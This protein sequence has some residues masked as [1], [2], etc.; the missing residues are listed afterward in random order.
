MPTVPRPPQLLTEELKRQAEVLNREAPLRF[1]ATLLGFCV[2]GIYLPWWI[3]VMM[4]T[5]DLAGEIVSYR[6]FRNVEALARDKWRKQAVIVATFTLEYCFVL[7]AGMLWHLDDPYAKALAVG[8]AAGTMMHIA[9]TRSIHLPVGLSGALGLFVVLAGSNTSFWLQNGMWLQLA[10]TSVCIVVTMAYFVWA[11]VSNHRLHSSTAASRL[12]A[13]QADAAKGRFLAEMSH[14]LRT[15]LNGILGMA[16]AEMREATDPASRKRLAVLV[17]SANGL[18]ALLNDILDLSAMEEGRMAIRPRPLAPADEITSAVALFRPA[19]EASGRRLMLTLDPTLSAPALIDGHRLRQCLNNL[20]S[21]A[22][23]HGRTATCITVRAKAETPPDG[24]P[25]LA[26]EVE[27]DGPGLAPQTTAPD[28]EVARSRGHGLGL[29]I[30]RGLAAQMGGDVQILPPTGATG[31]RFRL[32][33]ALPPAA[34]VSLASSQPLA[35]P[36]ALRGLRVLVVDDV[37]TN[38]LVATT[39]LRHLGAMA[40]EADSGVE[41][42]RRLAVEMVDLVLLDMNMPDLDGI[43]TLRRLRALPPPHG[44]VAVV[45][46]TADAMDHHRAHF[47]SQGLDGYL[48]KPISAERIAAEVQRVMAAR[49]LLRA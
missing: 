26:V 36:L 35:D 15:P 32:T 8:L 24:P 12:A 10:I 25:L 20:L 44:T 48:S 13:Q 4:M 7:P 41:A 11:M 37:A 29:S 17:D 38:R 30:S 23:R 31:A 16:D 3:I 21:N 5:G 27:D 33:I 19:A 42:L 43:E 22:I 2:A 34:P 49:T 28:D 39:Q 6:L 18:N 14:E 46:L 1:V 47:L 9:T 45:A 40:C